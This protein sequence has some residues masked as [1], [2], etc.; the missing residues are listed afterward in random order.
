MTIEIYA[1][2]AAIAVLL[3]ALQESFG[4]SVAVPADGYWHLP[5]K[6]A[7]DLSEPPGRPHA[8]AAW[9]RC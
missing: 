1:V 7:F 4:L 2:R 6:S 5:V 3:D 9:R 8:R